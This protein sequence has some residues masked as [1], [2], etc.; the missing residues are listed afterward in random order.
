MVFWFSSMNRNHFLFSRRIAQS[1]ET[2]RKERMMM[3]IS[4]GSSVSD[5]G[6]TD[7]MNY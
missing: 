7:E 6:E 5:M 3:T 2:G 1:D 4:G